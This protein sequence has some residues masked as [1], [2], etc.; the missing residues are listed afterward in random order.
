MAIFDKYRIHH[1]QK[2]TRLPFDFED[3]D[4]YVKLERS[5]FFSEALLWKIFL[6]FHV[7]ESAC[8]ISSV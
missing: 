7:S 2:K 4:K 3:V 8:G 5:V 1:L 6:Q